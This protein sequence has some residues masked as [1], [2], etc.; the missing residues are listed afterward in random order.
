MRIEIRNFRESDLE[1]FAR[2]YN[3]GEKGNPD[4]R[5][6]TADDFR[7]FVLEHPAYDPLGHFVAMKDGRIVCC[8]RGIYYPDHVKIKGPVGYL[9]FY[10]LPDY[11]GT[12]VEKEVFARI[13]EYMK[14]CGLTVVSTRVD[15]RFEAKVLLYER[16]GFSRSK[17]QNHGMELDPRLAEK[18]E[19]PEGYRIR[20]A[21]MPDE[22]ETMVRVF[23]AA[24]A[25]RDKYPPMS[26]ARFRRGWVMEDEENYS[27]FFLAEREFDNRVVGMVLSGINHGY[28]EEH[29]IKTG[30][31][32]ALA[33]IPSER[34]KG[35]GTV[36]TL[37]SI[38]WI[39][40]KGMDVAYVSVNA[41][42]QDA[43]RIYRTLGYQT[44]QIYQG[45][46][47]RIV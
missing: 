41:A 8:G 43:V 27:G 42:N 46:E 14:S 13:V 23:N 37:K 4:Y 31:S 15:T 2:L 47:M 18:P 21:R 39:A 29:S 44:V 22:S 36:L 1:G 33:V 26:L 24:F 6:L 5:S 40:K 32:Y 34:R 9:D 10:I 38:E 17:Y 45:Y 20:A 7:R 16:L 30:G 28:N 19:V 3:E 11:L 25:T 12:D 35:L